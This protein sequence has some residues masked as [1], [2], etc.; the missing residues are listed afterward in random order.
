MKNNN[1]KY[2]N[3]NF[4]IKINYIFMRLRLFILSPIFT[5]T[6]I[7]G[8]ILFLGFI[9]YS[10]PVMLCDGNG[11][12]LFELKT[13]LTSELAKYRISLINIWRMFWSRRAIKTNYASKIQKF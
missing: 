2:F 4:N 6:I 8:T 12:T 11:L 3:Q 5:I 13:Q 10:S 1:N 9:V 7:L